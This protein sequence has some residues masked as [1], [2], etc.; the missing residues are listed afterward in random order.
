MRYFNIDLTLTGKIAF[1]T[2]VIAFVCS[3]VAA[4]QTLDSLE[5]QLQIEIGKAGSYQETKQLRIETKRELAYREG[6]SGAERVRYFLDM[7]EEFDKYSF[8]STLHYIE[9][10]IELA[11]KEAHD[12]LADEARLLMCRTL[13]NAGRSKESIDILMQIDPMKLDHELFLQ[14][15]NIARKVYEDL[16]FYAISSRNAENYSQRYDYFK[17]TLLQIV[18]RNSDVYYSIIEKDLLDQRKLEECLQINS[19]RLDKLKLGS[20]KFSLVAFQRSLIY[21][22]QGDQE[23]QK[24]YLILSAISDIR[25]SIKDNASMAV[26]AV[27]EFD[28]GEIEKAYQYIEYAFQ[29]AVQFNSRL[30][31]FEISKTM[32][33]ITAS[34]QNLSNRQK[35]SLKSN[36]LIISI[37]GFILLITLLYIYRQYRKLSLAR[38]ALNSTVNQLNEANQKLTGFN[39]ELEKLN[40]D[41]SEAN[42]VKEQY[43]ANFLT[44]HSDYIEKI[45]KHQKLVKS[46]LRGRKIDKLMDLMSSQEYIDSEVKDFYTT[47]DNAFISIYPDFIVEL[48]KLLK[49]DQQIQLKEEEILNT[50]LRIFALIRLG[51]K[52][53]SNIARLLRYSVNTIYNYRVKIKNRAVVPRDD[54][55]DLIRNIGEFNR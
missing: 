32:S 53:S 41:L 8:D 52:D 3:N 20:S 19:K 1:I 16:S 39:Q 12:A 4:Q 9:L 25:A 21:E 34:Y 35:D 50:E 18:P 7:A 5:Q 46:M 30:R 28:K 15:C 44:I 24:Q 26:L 14:Y 23:A 37:L 33:M 36:L 10:S 31:F 13:G 29:D 17:D 48:N 11:G 6:I 22:L 40:L 55:E 54:F 38:A 45:D 42:H 43:I 47:F 27:M 49:P 2:L 51:I